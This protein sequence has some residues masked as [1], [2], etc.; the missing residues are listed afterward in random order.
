MD[1]KV[2]TLNA[3]PTLSVCI[4]HTVRLQKWLAFPRNPQLPAA[5]EH[6]DILYMYIHFKA[7]FYGAKI[8]IAQSYRLKVPDGEPRICLDWLIVCNNVPQFR[9]VLL[10]G[11]GCQTLLAAGIQSLIHI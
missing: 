2:S 10:A 5:L 9:S 8:R 6:S 4:C 7:F 3:F 1:H 11:S